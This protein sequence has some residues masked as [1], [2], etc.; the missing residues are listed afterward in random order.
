MFWDTRPPKVAQS[1]MAQLKNKDSTEIQTGGTAA[2][3]YKHLD[4]TWKPH[5]KVTLFKSEP[6][7]DHNPTKFSIAESQGDK[8]SREIFVDTIEFV[9]ILYYNKDF[10]LY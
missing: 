7:G 6:G 8:T 3:T 2:E 4:L 10:I 5:L 9:D 1:M